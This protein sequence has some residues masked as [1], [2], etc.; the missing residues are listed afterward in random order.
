MFGISS[1]HND[2]VLCGYSQRTRVIEPPKSR[3]KTQKIH[4]WLTKHLKDNHDMWVSYLKLEEAQKENNKQ[5]LTREVIQ[6]CYIGKR[7][8]VCCFVTP[9]KKKGKDRIL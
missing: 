1:K 5:E 7:E 8:S 9:Y 3:K 4:C 2:P 6:V